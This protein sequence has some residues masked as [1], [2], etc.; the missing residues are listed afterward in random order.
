E[1][2]LDVLSARP[3]LAAFVEQVVARLPERA[4]LVDVM[5]AAAQSFSIMRRGTVTSVERRVDEFAFV[6]DDRES[7]L[8]GRDQESLL[9][10]METSL[11]FVHA[12]FRLVMPLAATSGWRGV[13]LARTEG[14][15]QVPFDRHVPTSLGHRRYALLY[16]RA[17]AEQPVVLVRAN[18]PSL[19]M[20]TEEQVRMLDGG[21]QDRTFAGRVRMLIEEGSGDQTAVARSLG[22]SVATLRRRLVEEGASFRALRVETLKRQAEVL[23]DGQA[24]LSQVAEQLGFSDVRSFSRAYKTWTGVT[25]NASRRAKRLN[26]S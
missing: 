14:P 21:V 25:P 9:F 23:L 26:K 4:R 18:T 13:E 6:V 3:S 19:E 11:L 24:P 5:V 16:E 7:D 1:G 2:P 12:L 20:V 22:M 10:S 17:S 15:S 8:A